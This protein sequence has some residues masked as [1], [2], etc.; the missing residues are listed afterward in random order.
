[1]KKN[2]IRIGKHNSKIIVLTLHSRGITQNFKN[3]LTWAD[4]LRKIENIAKTRKK[5]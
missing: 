2:R 5:K 4:G 1:M 3:K